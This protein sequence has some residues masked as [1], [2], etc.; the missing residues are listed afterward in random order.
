MS[1]DSSPRLFPHAAY[2]ASQ[3]VHQAVVAM[4]RRRGVRGAELEDVTQDVLETVL[5]SPTPP[6]SLE[7]C[8]ALAC[9]IARD[10]AIDRFRKRRSRAKYNAGL[11]EN[12]DDRPAPDPV[13]SGERDPIDA[14]KQIDCIRREIAAGR[15]TRRQVAILAAEAEDVPQAET[16]AR[17]NVAHQTVRN[18]LATARS[19]ARAS[20]ASYLAVAAFA[21]AGFIVWMLRDRDQMAKTPP[22]PA[23]RP[24]DSQTPPQPTQQER[25]EDMRRKAL[26]D[27]DV[28]RWDECL[29]GLQNAEMI[30]PAADTDLRVQKALDQA[31][32]HVLHDH[33]PPRHDDKP[34]L[35]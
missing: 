16:A 5:E 2:V 19:T 13:S 31:R 14:R 35:Q 3:E 30:Y 6:P 20:W 7:D 25:A 10:I 9:K 32:Q 33:P 4:L 27:C 11:Y 24:V 34:R 23:P 22:Q 26:H 21:V 29:E 1:L 18:D 12:P 8:V 15:I 17:L 28:G